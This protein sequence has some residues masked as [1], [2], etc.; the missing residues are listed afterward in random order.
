MLSPR[1][2]PQMIGLG[3]IEAVPERDILALADPEDADGDGISGRPNPVLSERI[4]SADARA[5]RAEGR[6]NRRSASRPPPPFSGDIGTSTSILADAWGECTEAQATAA[7]RGD[8]GTPEAGDE[9]LD[10]VTFYSRNVAVPAR[11]DVGD[12][13]VLAGKRVFY[14]AGCPACHSSEV[15]HRPAGGPAGAELPADLALHRPPA[16]RHG[17][18]LADRRPEARADGREWR[19]APLWGIGLTA[20]VTGHRASCTTAGRAHL[21]EAILWHGGEAQAA[22]DAVAALPKDERV[23]LIR[24]LASLDADWGQSPHVDHPGPPLSSDRTGEA[25]VAP[26]PVRRPEPMAEGERGAAWIVLRNR[27]A[28]ARAGADC[29]CRRAEGVP[30]ARRAGKAL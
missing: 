21:L 30:S 29:A 2:A 3:L 23:A 1:V 6:R 22:R 14:E 8:G 25:P 18:G 11:R 27:D 16:A 28:P 7:G 13:Q 20:T 10:L 26:R 4:R 19:T 9:V 24:F 12:P 5:L 17:R 15:R